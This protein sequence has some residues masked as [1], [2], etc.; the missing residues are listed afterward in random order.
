[1]HQ[2][3]RF[4]PLRNIQTLQQLQSSTIVSYA[5]Y[6]LAFPFQ[7]PRRARG[8]GESTHLLRG[9]N[10]DPLTRYRRRPSAF[11]RHRA[12]SAIRN[13][14]CGHDSA[15]RSSSCPCVGCRRPRR[16]AI[17]GAR[18]YLASFQVPTRS[19]ESCKSFRRKCRRPRSPLCHLTML[20]F[21]EQA[22]PGGWQFSVQLDCFGFSNWFFFQVFSLL[23]LLQG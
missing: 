4:V 3:T 1:M 20:L 10:R 8:R 9:S 16:V 13:L 19:S 18:A 21:L 17:K 23:A 7:L 14:L 22:S 15:G 6:I 12:I 2:P 5:A 11:S